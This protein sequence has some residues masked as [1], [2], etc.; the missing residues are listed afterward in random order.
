MSDYL[1]LYRGGDR[2]RS[3]ED[4]QQVMQRWINWLGDLKAKGF[5]KNSGEPLE[6]SGKTVRNKTEISDGPYA[7]AK[8]L[9]GGFSIVT[10]DSLQHAAELA[11][12][13]PIFEVGGVVEV[14]P[15]MEM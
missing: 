2:E 9:V 4:M 3:P 14:R 10:A 11:E 7:E 13:C 12:G 15:I 1:Y 5:L 8:D 6:Q